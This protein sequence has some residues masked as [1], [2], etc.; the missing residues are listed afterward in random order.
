MIRHIEQKREWKRLTSAA[1]DHPFYDRK[2]HRLSEREAEKLLASRDLPDGKAV[3]MKICRELEIYIPAVDHG[4]KPSFTAHGAG[5][6]RA[7]WIAAAAAIVLLICFFTMTKPGIALAKEISSVIVEWFTGHFTAHNPEPVDAAPIDFSTLPDEYEDIR[8]LAKA[9]GRTLVELKDPDYVLEEFRVVA[10]VD[11]SLMVRMKYQSVEKELL[12]TQLVFNS[13][14]IWSTSLNIDMAT[15]ETS[16][17]GF[18]FYVGETEDGTVI[19]IMQQDGYEINL[20]STDLSEE[21]M[22]ALLASLVY[23]MP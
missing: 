18:Q 7:R 20:K 19:A 17:I 11:Q 1:F 8:A 22:K 14:I 6:K 23:V 13:D 5:A 2:A 15:C 21:E 4:A 3:I 16:P 9:T 10:M 12:L